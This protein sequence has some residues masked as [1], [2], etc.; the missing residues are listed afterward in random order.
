M[1]RS[2]A[3][4]ALTVTESCSA[5]N[6]FVREVTGPDE[7]GIGIE[8]HWIIWAVVKAERALRPNRAGLPVT[9]VEALRVPTGLLLVRALPVCV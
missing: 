7:L 6:S 5:V 2:I 4:T 3:K 8:V 9:V 1:K